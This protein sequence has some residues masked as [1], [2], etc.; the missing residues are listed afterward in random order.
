MLR[1]KLFEHVEG[2]VSLPTRPL[3]PL[4]VLMLSYCT[5]TCLL[6]LPYHTVWKAGR[7]KQ[8]AQHQHKRG[9]GGVPRSSILS[10]IYKKYHLLLFVFLLFVYGTYLTMYLAKFS[11][12]IEWQGSERPRHTQNILGKLKSFF[13][14]NIFSFCP[15]LLK[16][17]YVTVCL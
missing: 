2:G 13:A 7:R 9:G 16:T 10:N 14:K 3:H 12:E 15:V 6:L 4:P 5:S 17:E 1:L 11:T 8:V